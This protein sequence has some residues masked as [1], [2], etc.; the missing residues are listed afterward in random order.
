MDL[1]DYSD[2]AENY[3][4]Y[5]EGI[6]SQT[7][8]G[9][10]SGFLTFHLDLAERYGAGRILDVGCGTGAT[11]IPLIQA[12]YRVTGI[13]ISDA[14]LN[15]LGRKLADLP[16][17]VRERA[18]LVRAN[19]TSF[20]LQGQRSLALIPRSGFLHLLRSDEQERA[21]KNICRHLLSGG[22]LCF[23][24]FDPNYTLIAGSLKGSNPKPFL[25]TEYTNVMG[26]RER[27]WN[28]VEFDPATQLIEGSWIFETLGK[29]DSVIEQR[30]RPVRLRW[31]FEPEMRHLL[32]LCGFEVLEIYSSYEKAPKTYGGNLIW[33]VRKAVTKGNQ[34][35]VRDDRIKTLARG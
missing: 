21:L 15:V 28:A 35:E 14:M 27:I 22:I 11:L 16:A 6:A 29:D 19:M 7:N 18:Q 33:I 3:D 20:R 26:Y 8:G 30:T 31:S 5:V 32:R 23:N 1:H 34:M 17:N 13:D 10:T 12:G 24:T 9:L 25:R 4:R 2:V